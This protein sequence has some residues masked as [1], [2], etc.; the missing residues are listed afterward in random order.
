MVAMPRG[1]RALKCGRCGQKGGGEGG[2]RVKK[3]KKGGKSQMP[4]FPFCETAALLV[5]VDEILICILQLK[6]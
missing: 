3:G 4:D 2:T 6:V 5:S 1:W